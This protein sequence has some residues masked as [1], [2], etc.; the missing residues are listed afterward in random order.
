MR[1]A[2][3]DRTSQEGILA[4]TKTGQQNRHQNP[5]RLNDKNAEAI[6]NFI[7]ELKLNAKNI[8]F[9]PSSCF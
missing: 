2:L 6:H 9:I 4:V 1:V 8:I 5:F 3:A 7:R